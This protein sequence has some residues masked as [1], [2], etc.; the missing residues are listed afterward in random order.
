MS[1]RGIT[2]LAIRVL[3]VLALAVALV[4]CAPGTDEQPARE[5]VYGL[6]LVPSGIDPHLHASAEM[7]IPLRSVY[8]TL[9]Y[10]D[11]E[12]LEFIP[13]LAESWQIE[14]AGLVYTFKL[15]EDVKFHDG[16]PFNADAVRV[17]IERVLAAG[18]SS[19][20]AA[21]LLGPVQ[22]VRVN[23]AFSV[24]L[25]LSE[26]F[27]PLLDGLSQPYLGMAS[28]AA[29]SQ[30]D[31]ETYQL[32]QVGTGP[33][34]F[35]EYV[36]NDRLVLEKNPDYAWGPALVTN[37][38]VPA[39]ERISFRFLT[40]AA[41]RTLA[42]QSGEVD[43]VGELL[44]SDARPLSADG[45]IQ[46][47]AVAIPGQP[48]QFLFNTNRVPTSSLAVRQALILAADRQA[49]VQSIFQGFSPVAYG[50]LSA[51]TLYYD[52]AVEG[53]YAYDPVQAVALFNST[54][55]IDT[56]G[57]G[58]RD[59]GSAPLVLALVVPPWGQ[60]PDVA[61]LLEDQW[62]TTLRVQVEIKQVASF[63]MLSDVANSGEY[64]LI[65]I[66]F[67][68]FDPVLLNTFYRSDGRLNWSRYADRELDDWLL[69][70]QRELDEAR[71]PGWYSLI[72]QRIMDQALVLPIRDYVNLNGVRPGIFGLHYDVQ[73]WF[74][75]LTDLS[76][77][78]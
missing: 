49:I 22:E 23:G 62:E 52:P 42:L 73:G 20:K 21:Q 69:A 27:A 15:R 46:L 16:T 74:P 70:G 14:E 31:T 33:Y 39:V 53:R 67:F 32:H 28:P 17:N 41:T 6:T 66:N 77:G 68:G 58:W 7:G 11:P 60:N 30:W 59:D 51:A 71:R 40:D 65:G 75:Y 45:V 47:A 8:D 72:Q 1:M 43:I 24:S 54:G 37:R 26:P 36:F 12:T 61:Q 9:V 55:W 2:M 76:F 5:L 44:P 18:A 34:R 19:L 38:G 48:Q 10:R 56:D 35:V 4:S 64:N 78:Q 57:D 25:I 50:P 3:M 63:P 29:L 13:G